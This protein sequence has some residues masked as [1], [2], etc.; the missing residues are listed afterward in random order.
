MGRSNIR[1][2]VAEIKARIGCQVC[3][4]SEPCCLDFHHL[5]DKQ[6]TIGHMLAQR[7]G[8]RQVLLEMSKCALVCANCHRKLHA[9]IIDGPKE[10]IEKLIESDLDVVNKIIAGLPLIE[11]VCKYCKGQFKHKLK[12]TYCSHKCLKKGRKKVPRPHKAKLEREIKKHSWVA[13]GRKYGVTDNAIRK[14]AR[15]YK[16]I[17]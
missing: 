15:D 14:W 4:E 16:I 2:K 1:Q 7:F 17:R 9:G 13:L 3:G 6:Y 5:R 8:S 12:R 11:Q 10:T